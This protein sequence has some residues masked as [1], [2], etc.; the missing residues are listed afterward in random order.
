MSSNKG[1]PPPPETTPP[2]PTPLRI[3]VVD[4]GIW[5]ESPSFNDAGMSEIP[6]RWK[7]SC[8]E[9]DGFNSSLCN[10]KLIGV[11]YFNEGVRAANHGVIISP[12]SAREISGHDTHVASTAAGNYIDG[13]SFFDGWSSAGVVKFMEFLN[14]K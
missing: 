14:L 1:Y 9:G 7:G 3:G 6:A 12:N 10:K 13:V 5:P 11:K 8:Q 4:S 2:P